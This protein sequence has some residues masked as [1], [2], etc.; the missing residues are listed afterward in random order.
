M[1]LSFVPEGEKESSL[2][3]MDNR[4]NTVLMVAARYVKLSSNLELTR[5]LC[6]H[7]IRGQHW[8]CFGNAITK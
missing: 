8:A 3:H 2:N 5:T 4:G 7:T 6:T 1:L